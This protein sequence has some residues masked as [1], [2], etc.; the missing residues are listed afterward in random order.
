M[1]ATDNRGELF[2]DGAVP[3]VADEGPQLD[4]ED[5]ALVAVSHAQPDE[6]EQAAFLQ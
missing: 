1:L 3:A 6:G 5:D 2:R 4:A